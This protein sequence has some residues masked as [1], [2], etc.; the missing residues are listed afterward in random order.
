MQARQGDVFVDGDVHV[1]AGGKPVKRERRR[2]VLAHGEATGHAHAIGTSS[3]A[4]Y[5][6]PTTH[7]RRLEAPRGCTIQHEEHG[8]IQLPGG[9][10]EVVRQREYTPAE[11]RNV[12]D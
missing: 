8:K 6:D 4:L 1:P 11:I 10:Y 3:A 7:V 12:A 5:E 9:S 2:I